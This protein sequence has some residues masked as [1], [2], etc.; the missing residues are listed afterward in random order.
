MLRFFLFVLSMTAAIPGR[1]DDPSRAEIRYR[2]DGFTLQLPRGVRAD[3]AT[4][5][6]DFDLY[7][8]TYKGEVILQ[9][10]VG[11]APYVK[12]KHLREQD[13]A[14][15]KRSYSIR[16]VTRKTVGGL[17]SREVLFNLSFRSKGWPRYFHFWY[18]NMSPNPA[19]IADG[20]I[21]STEPIVEDTEGTKKEAE[22]GGEPKKGPQQADEKQDRQA[23]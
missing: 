7:K 8:F 2:G 17:A 1:A 13:G 3:K 14:G 9:M 19:R 22:R 6:Q 15:E 18:S 4:P 23:N 10:Y 12:S 20:I 5:V 21:A 11:N 16:S